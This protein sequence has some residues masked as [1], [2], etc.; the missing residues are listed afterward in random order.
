MNSPSRLSSHFAG[1]WVAQVKSMKVQADA[2][3][4]DALSVATTWGFMV[5]LPPIPQGVTFLLS[6]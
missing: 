6:S 5:K 2:A 4:R 3:G 1:Q